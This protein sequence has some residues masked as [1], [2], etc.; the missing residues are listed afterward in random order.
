VHF[1]SLDSLHGHD[2]FLVAGEAAQFNPRLAAFLNPAHSDGV[3]SVRAYVS[4]LH[5]F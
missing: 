2:A 4:S 3:Q 5:R 1:E